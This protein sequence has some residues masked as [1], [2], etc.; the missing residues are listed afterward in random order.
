[1][2]E[3]LVKGGGEIFRI[4]KNT[5]F[6]KKEDKEFSIPLSPKN[7]TSRVGFTCFCCSSCFV[8]PYFS[9]LSS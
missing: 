6:P 3:R 7:A 5:T 8:L 9:D 4:V 2:G 1:M